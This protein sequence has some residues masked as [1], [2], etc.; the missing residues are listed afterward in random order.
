[1]LMLLLMAVVLYLRDL[2][3]WRLYWSN[4]EAAENQGNFKPSLP[5]GD[6]SLSLR[7]FK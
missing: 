5:Y 2:A 4:L 7:V 6:K 1:M 3:Q